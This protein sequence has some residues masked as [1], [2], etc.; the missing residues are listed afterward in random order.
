MC[1]YHVQCKQR[2]KPSDHA[3]VSDVV[4]GLVVINNSIDRF[5]PVTAFNV[6]L[7]RLRTLTVHVRGQ[8]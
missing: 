5:C 7:L 3:E 8:N 4:I 2:F 6:P 1:P